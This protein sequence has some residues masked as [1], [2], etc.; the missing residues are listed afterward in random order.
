VIPNINNNN[1]ANKNDCN[2]D[3]KNEKS[4]FIVSN[5]T[6]ISN[7]LKASKQPK[8][9]SPKRIENVVQKNVKTKRRFF[10]ENMQQCQQHESEQGGASKQLSSIAI[11]S[12]ERLKGSIYLSINLS[13]TLSIYTL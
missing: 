2:N 1:V 6:K 11:R 13:L 9:P 12:S 5:I 8:T 3:I 4:S 7:T 10:L